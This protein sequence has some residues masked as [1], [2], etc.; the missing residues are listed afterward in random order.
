VSLTALLVA[1]A[2]GADPSGP[3]CAPA[4]TPTVA[5]SAAPPAPPAPPALRDEEAVLARL[6][7]LFGRIDGPVPAEAWRAL[8]PEAL[9]LLERIAAGTG[10]AVTRARALEGAAALGAGGEVHRRI[11]RDPT[12]PLMVRTAAI[13]MLGR[14]VPPAALKA[15]L[16]ALLEADPD[17]RIRATAAATLAREAPAEGCAAVRAR[18]RRERDD[19]RPAFQRALSDCGDR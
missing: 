17:L 10:S 4:S 18:A 9:P 15:E 19:E 1:L 5:A 13:R 6:K 2:F 16:G 12:A 11:S 3:V 8:P 14:I 7:P